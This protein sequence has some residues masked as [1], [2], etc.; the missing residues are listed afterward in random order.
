MST[1]NEIVL[2]P[3]QEREIAKKFLGDDP[4]NFVKKSEAPVVLSEEEKKKIEEKKQNEIVATGLKEGWFNKDSYDEFQRAKSSDPLESAKAKFIEDNP[5]LE[6]HESV[7]K[8]LLAVDEDDE[9]YEFG[10]DELVPNKKKLAAKK[11]TQKMAD[12]YMKSKYGGILD[13]EKKYE[14]LQLATKNSATVI[15]AIS[16]IPSTIEIEVPFSTGEGNEPVLEKYN[17]SIDKEDLDAVIES[18]SKDASLLGKKEIDSKEVIQNAL[19]FIQA[20]SFNK[21]VSEIV[22]VAVSNARQSYE[23]GEK[24]IVP[25]RQDTKITVNKKDQFARKHGLI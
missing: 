1:E 9:V 17:I 3:E 14:N 22:S 4:E 24:G 19:M 18:F 2:T 10:S 16:K 12:E 11:L 7:F 8:E 21:I 6:N 20:R 13:A 15:D 23:R 5:D 25:T